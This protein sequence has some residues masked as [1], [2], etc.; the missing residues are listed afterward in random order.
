MKPKIRDQE[1]PGRNGPGQLGF[2]LDRRF[3]WKEGVKLK[4]TWRV[5]MSEIIMVYLVSSVGPA[6]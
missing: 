5:A 6:S 3:K 1:G 4:E 2:G